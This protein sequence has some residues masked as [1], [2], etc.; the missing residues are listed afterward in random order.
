MKIG[1][2]G[3][4]FDPPHLGHIGACKAFLETV[5]LDHLYVIPA[6]IPPHKAVISGSNANNRFDMTKLAFS[7]LSDKIIVSDLEFKRE[8][9]SYTADT[10]KYFKDNY[11]DIEI[12]FLCGTDMILTMDMWYHPEYI[13]DNATIVYVRRE[14]DSETTK[15]IDE[16]CSQYRE[17][18]NANI[19]PL[20]LNVVEMSSSDIRKAI[21]NNEELTNYLSSEIINYIKINRLYLEN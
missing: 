12:Y 15:R 17:K 8:G 1:I 14:N 13:F 20:S 2:F 18:F 5:S 16:K 3:G 4:T 9:K 19:L 6:F 21:A 7:T 10:L 11:K